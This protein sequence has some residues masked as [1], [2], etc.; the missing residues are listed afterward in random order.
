MEIHNKIF[1]A[2]REWPPAVDDV[3]KAPLDTS[4]VRLISGA[5][6][7]EKLSAYTH[8]KALW[9]FDINESQLDSICACST[10]E[11]LYIENIKT[12]NFDCLKNLSNLRILSIETCSKAA[13]LEAFAELQS[14][15]GLAITH[16]KNVH[17]LGPLAKLGSLR[18]L[19]VAGSMWTRM[20]VHSF[21]PLEKLKNLEFLHLTNIKAE[22][23]ILRPF[24]ALQGLRQL[25]IANFY[26]MSE[27]AWLSQRLRTTECTWFKPYIEMKHV[28]C[29]KCRKTTMVMLTGK[30]KPTV[31]KL[32]NKQVLEKHIREWNGFTEKVA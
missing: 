12:E 22:D 27:F 11:S 29:N 26:P 32:C 24:A 2:R 5:K 3:M 6:H 20:H 16:F 15:S 18:A 31:C 19:A 1:P 14:L 7:L 4:R 28:E 8:L 23:E 21:K 10:L 13:S 17:D 30:R 9:C 25:D